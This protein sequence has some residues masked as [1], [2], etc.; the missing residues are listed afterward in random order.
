LKSD[1][2]DAALA[3]RQPVLPGAGA[4]GDRH[5]DNA[6]APS[7]AQRLGSRDARRRARHHTLDDGTHLWLW[8]DAMAREVLLELAED[9]RITA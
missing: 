2:P 3:L 7:Y 9:A 4:C 5:L 6:H 1:P 8:A